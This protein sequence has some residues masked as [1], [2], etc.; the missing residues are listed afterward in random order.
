[1][2]GKGK[3]DVRFPFVLVRV[4]LIRPERAYVIPRAF[5]Y[6]Q[7]RDIETQQLAA[8]IAPIE[9]LAGIDESSVRKTVEVLPLPVTRCLL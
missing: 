6:V 5:D 8:R 1:V 9:A 4:I 2:I 3:K 7:K